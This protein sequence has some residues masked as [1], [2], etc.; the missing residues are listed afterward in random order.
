M[1]L[2]VF[3]STGFIGRHL[4]RALAA[5][6]FQVSVYNRRSWGQLPPGVTEHVGSLDDTARLKP[7][8]RSADG[9][10][11]LVWI[12]Y[13]HSGIRGPHVGSRTNVET[14]T[15]LFELAAQEGALGEVV[16]EADDPRREEDHRPDVRPDRDARPAADL[17]ARHF[18][19]RASTTRTVRKRKKPASDRK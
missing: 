6:K 19:F 10:F 14:A 16:D 3:G 12:G 7:V 9:L 18:H 2:M 5:R 15:S 8:L 1:H 17:R 4:V 11:Y 13:P